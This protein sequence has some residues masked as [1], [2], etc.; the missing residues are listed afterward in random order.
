MTS[1]IFSSGSRP[2]SYLDG[3]DSEQAYFSGE[4]TANPLLRPRILH[5][6]RSGRDRWRLALEYMVR[7]VWSACA[8]LGLQPRAVQLWL[9]HRAY[10]GRYIDH[11][12]AVRGLDRL[13]SALLP[14]E[15]LRIRWVN[16][17][18]DYQTGQ[19][20]DFSTRGQGARHLLAGWRP[21]DEAGT[22]MAAPQASLRLRLANPTAASVTLSTRWDGAEAFTLRAHV[23]GGPPVSIPTGAQQGQITTVDLPF[24][25][26][27]KAQSRTLT[28]TFSAQANPGVRPSDLPRLV[29]LKI[30]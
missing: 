30:E 7:P 8:C 27:I 1:L 24:G 28:I 17:N 6:A 19:S 15:Q 13:A 21:P 5:A 14:Q 9:K 16:R 20:V 25:G 3:D 4:L 26:G 29:E 2:N 11:L 10:P 18:C 23:N 12:R 22:A